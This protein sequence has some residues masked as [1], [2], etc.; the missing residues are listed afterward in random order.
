MIEDRV[1]TDRM[2]ADCHLHTEFSTDSTIK[3]EVQIQQAIRLGM[4]H[5]CITDHMDMDFPG[6]EF[7]FDTDLAKLRLFGFERQSVYGNDPSFCS[8]ADLDHC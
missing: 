5:M 1:T 6:G 2:I 7:C 3:M 4:K 8:A